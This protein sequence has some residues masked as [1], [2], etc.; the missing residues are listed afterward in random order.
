MN[1]IECIMKFNVKFSYLVDFIIW[2]YHLVDCCKT[3]QYLY[4]IL[5]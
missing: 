5:Q 3:Y 2:N 1:L 4:K